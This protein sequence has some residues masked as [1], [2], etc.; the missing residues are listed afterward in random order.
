MTIFL[1]VATLHLFAVASPGPDFILISRQ[2][3]R[4]GREV[5]IWTSFGIA[6]GILF[7]AGLSIAGLSILLKQQP[8]I[9]WYMKIV[10]S[11]YIAYLGFVSLFSTSYIQT[12]GS[13]QV[14]RVRVLK[15]IITGLLT[16][17]LNPKALI[18]FITVFTIVIDNQISLSLKLLLGIYMSAAT[19]L[20]FSFVSVLLTNKTT[21][22]RFRKVIPW[23]ERTTGL[24]LLFIAM[25]LILQ[26][27]LLKYSL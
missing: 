16:N 12:E 24:M 18:F 21:I 19:F 13:M 27:E 6:I 5:S 14:Q 20:W 22:L 1:T 10:A 7:H 2:S 9:F 15:S 11:I 8:D 26:Q 4:Y 23:V 25:Q 3:F 17:L